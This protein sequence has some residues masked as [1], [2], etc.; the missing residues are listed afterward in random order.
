MAPVTQD[1]KAV[2]DRV[3]K[4]DR[5]GRLDGPPWSE[6]TPI[7]DEAL[8]AVG[9]V[10]GLLADVDDGKDYK[11]RYLLHAM[12]VYV[13]RPGMEKQRA[14]YLRALES[15]IAG[16]RP[17]S[18]KGFLVRQLQV[19]GDASCIK[20][21]G[22]LLLDSEL[23]EY[24][25]Q[26]LLAIGGSAAAF[27]EALP[28]AAGGPRLTIVQAL[29]VL[30]DAASVEALTAAARDESQDVRLAA[31]WGLAN[32]GTGTDVLLAAKEE[33]FARFRVVDA[34]LIL[35]ERLE[36]GGKTAEAEKI[37]AHIDQ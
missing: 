19:A 3:G 26:A 10:V 24:A 36:A 1:I 29:G 6:M 4:L 5:I 37:R 22:A 13:C 2:V 28:K 8:P 21:L 17:P 14:A 32:I 20:P 25:A 34:C 33:G 11:A 9:D 31:L 23:Y 18:V 15:A 7:L 16:E 27:R 30:R 12:A 35:A